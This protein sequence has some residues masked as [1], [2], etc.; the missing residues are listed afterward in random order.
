MKRHHTLVIAALLAAAGAAPAAPGDQPVKPLPPNAAAPKTDVQ[1]KTTSLP[2][3]GLFEGDKL[4]ASAQRR[5]TEL[6]IDAISLQ[7]DVALVVPTGPWKTEG[8]GADERDLTPARLAAVKR[9]LTQRG[10]DPKHIFVESRIDEKVSEPRLD[11]QI[12]GKPA[13]D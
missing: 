4:S 5:L 2:A 1:T 6:I 7:V 12:A 8:T 11:I 9:F 3:R 13:N 10:V